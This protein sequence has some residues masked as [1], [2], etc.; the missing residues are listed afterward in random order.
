M[1][2]L[3]KITF[4]ALMNTFIN[5]H[6]AIGKSVVFKTGAPKSGAALRL[7]IENSIVELG[8]TRYTH[9]IQVVHPMPKPLFRGRGFATLEKTSTHLPLTYITSASATISCESFAIRAQIGERILQVIPDVLGLNLSLPGKHWLGYMT[10]NKAYR[11][12]DMALI[13]NIPKGNTRW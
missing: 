4:E 10:Y 11:G 3:K 2:D 6:P 13:L 7:R 9:Y 12:N 8:D 1:L 5:S